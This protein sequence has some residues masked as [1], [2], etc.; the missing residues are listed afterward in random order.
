MEGGDQ[1][2]FPGWSFR[3]LVTFRKITNLAVILS[4]SSK[5]FYSNG[6]FSLQVLHQQ[7]GRERQWERGRGGEEEGGKR[8]RNES[9][10]EEGEGGKENL[11]YTNYLPFIR[12]PNCFINLSFFVWTFSMSYKY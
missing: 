12:L 1:S 5:S 4:N 10:S 2:F 9:E 6:Y 3:C 7:E 8:E 11:I